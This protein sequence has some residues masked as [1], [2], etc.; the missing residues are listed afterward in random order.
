MS[1]DPRDLSP[2]EQHRLIMETIAEWV[3]KLLNGEDALDGKIERKTGFVLLVYP[4]RDE[5]GRCN[6][7]SNGASR[8]QVA[9]FMREQ[10]RVFERNDEEPDLLNID[11]NM[12][13]VNAACHELREGTITREQCKQYLIERCS[14]ADH[15]LDR[16]LDAYDP[17]MNQ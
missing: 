5:S 12:A 16:L 4:F 17:K 9:Q 7:I 1:R 15:N 14:V 6:Y 8:E 10:I 11:E 2:V 3:D 13:K